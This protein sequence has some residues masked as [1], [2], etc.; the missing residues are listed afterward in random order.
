M[1]T[2]SDLNTLYDGDG[3]KNNQPKWDEMSKRAKQCAG[4][5]VLEHWIDDSLAKI[6]KDFYKF[7]TQKSLRRNYGR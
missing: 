1:P 3:A 5:T 2:N 7:S 6:E 4:L